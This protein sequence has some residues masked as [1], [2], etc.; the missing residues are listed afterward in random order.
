MSSSISTTNNKE[1][2]RLL[3]DQRIIYTRDS[4]GSVMIRGEVI[5]NF[6]K[7]T[8]IV[9]TMQLVFEGIQRYYTWPGI[10]E[11]KPIG[12]EIETKL[13]AIELSLLPPNSSGIM[14]AGIQRFPF[15]F[16]IPANIS[17][18]LYIKDRIEIFYQIRATIIK[19]SQ[20]VYNSQR[21]SWISRVRPTVSDKKIIAC[22]S[23]RIIRSLETVMLHNIEGTSQWFSGNSTGT[24][25][26]STND[27]ATNTI[28][29]EPLSQS[30]PTMTADAF[31]PWDMYLLSENRGTLDEQHDLLAYSLAGRSADNYDSSVDEMNKVHGIRYK[32]GVDRTAIVLGTSVGIEFLVEP[33]A[34]DARIQSIKL[35]ILEDREYRMK[36]PMH[37]SSEDVRYFNEGVNMV[38]KWAFGYPVEATKNLSENGKKNLKK[39]GKLTDSS[40]RYVHPCSINREHIS[41]FDARNP[42]VQTQKATISFD[43]NRASTSETKKALEADEQGDQSDL[44]QGSLYSPI[45]LKSLDLNVKVGE[46][47]GGRFVMPVPDCSSILNPSMIHDSIKINH[48]LR[49]VVTIAC[50]GK[51]FDIT[52]ES[53]MHMLDCRLVTFGDDTILPPPPSYDLTTSN[54]LDLAWSGTFWEQRERITSEIGFGVYYPC[55]CELRKNKSLRPPTHSKNNPLNFL[56]KATPPTQPSYPASLMPEWGPPPSYKEN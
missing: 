34:Y 18:S 46:Y 13:Q 9:G 51:V 26:A 36:V 54:Q 30:S 47:F 15:E 28:P 50:H 43:T 39:K 7:D 52:L 19:S 5:V 4:L 14:P 22:T 3:V 27:E 33:T 10:I 55:P 8:M 38:L 35:D 25:S 37:N 2:L 31:D 16:P 1:Q 24:T 44:A 17:T 23:I 32:I 41:R 40:S 6:P 45:N 56:K 49:L 48:W 20:A 12:E 53:P 11:T 29:T 21:S 42:T